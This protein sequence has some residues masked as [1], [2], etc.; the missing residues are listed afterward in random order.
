MVT[1]AAKGAAVAVALLLAGCA[2]SDGTG[3]RARRIV[4]FG[5]S[6]TQLGDGPGGYV[7]LVRDSLRSAGVEAE[8]VGAGIS[9]N[10]VT[11]LQARLDTDVLAKRPSLVV[12]YIG[13]NDVWHNQ[14][15]ERGLSGTPRETYRTVLNDV[16]GRAAASG[17]QVVLATPSVIGER[18][19]GANRWDP[20][21]DEYAAIS[22][23]VA[24]EKGAVLMDLRSAFTAY[25][26][27]NNPEDRK[28]G[29]LT[30]DGVHLN[31]AG[32]RLVM[33]DVMRTLDGLGYFFP[34]R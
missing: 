18:T 16:V 33:E 20:M 8:V 15:A 9:G 6:I 17:A 32:N 22:R 3:D 12:I 4:F 31:A 5:D 13:I 11:D 19:G 2:A 7:S 1:R 10:K 21:L 25:I 26:A 23:A 29:I 14:F 34:N 28:K 30:N 27:A 24:Q